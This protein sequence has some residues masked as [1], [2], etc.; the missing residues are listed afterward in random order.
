MLE[1]AILE[2]QIFKHFWGS[3]PPEPWKARTF[4]TCG[5]PLLF[6]SPG[7]TPGSGVWSRLVAFLQIILMSLVPY[8]N[9]KG[10]NQIKEIN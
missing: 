3:M 2:I 9:G 10:T 4:G 6:E 5:V 8:Y 7:S 1:T